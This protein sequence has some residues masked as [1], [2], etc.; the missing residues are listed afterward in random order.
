MQKNIVLA[1]TGSI[2]AYKACDII[3]TFKYN[4]YNVRVL[5][6]QAGA[7]FIT[8]L[9]LR[10]LSSH[11][12]ITNTFSDNC[13]IEHVELAPWASAFVIAPATANIIAKCAHGIA[14]DIISTTYLC[15]QDKPVFFAPAMNTRMWQHQQTIAN[16][17][18]LKK[19]SHIIEP[20]KKQLAC[21]DMG[22]GAL[23]NPKD[24]V[25]YILKTLSTNE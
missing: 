11:P 15:M 23:A 12:V 1:I 8:P 20:I 22:I 18:K 2:A 17:N 24:I 19:Q 10:T 13:S 21:G 9:T 6:S 4:N 16:I 3:Q 7:E 25:Q 5:L 14:D